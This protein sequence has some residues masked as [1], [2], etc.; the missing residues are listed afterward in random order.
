M[1]ARN[2]GR[3]MKMSEVLYINKQV[4][5][6]SVR[7]DDVDWV[8]AYINGE[9][10]NV[11]RL[12]STTDKEM[13]NKGMERNFKPLVNTEDFAI[14]IAYLLSCLSRTDNLSSKSYELALDAYGR[15]I[16]KNMNFSALHKRILIATDSEGWE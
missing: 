8:R 16:S 7:E 1:T 13:Y 10:F 4:E 6:V 5:F 11:I 9:G 12:V 14:H 3:V 15:F 2:M